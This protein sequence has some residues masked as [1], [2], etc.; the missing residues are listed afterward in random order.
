MA[1][2]VTLDTLDIE[3]ASVPGSE[4]EPG[5]VKEPEEKPPV[6]WYRTTRFRVLCA[7]AVLLSGIG[8]SAYWWI[9]PGK[10]QAPVPVAQR[11]AP[12][13][14]AGGGNFEMVNDFLV[15]LRTGKGRQKVAVFDLAFELHE[16]RQASFKENRVRIRSSIYQTV[17]Q[18]TNDAMLGSGS[19]NALKN[20]IVAELEHYLGKDSIKKI[21]FTKYLVL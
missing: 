13:A 20:E 5:P 15:P 11:P 18:K 21:Y 16:G 2:K 6:R 9:S 4:E 17:H 14:L 19:M 10:K 12:A 8:I 7:A 3:E 1:K